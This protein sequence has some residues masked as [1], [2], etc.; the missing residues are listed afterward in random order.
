MEEKKKKSYY[1]QEKNKR[2]QDYIRNNY[3]QISVRIP[4][5]KRVEYQ[6]AIENLGIKDLSLNKYIVQKLEELL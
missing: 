1:N 4:K 3:D 6:K 5:G 2:T